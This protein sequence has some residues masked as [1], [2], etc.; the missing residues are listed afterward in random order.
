MLRPAEPEFSSEPV[1][2]W[3]AWRL[4]RT[5][6]GALRIA[7]ATPRADWEPGVA[8]KATCTGAHTRMYLV[9]NPELVS[10]HRSPEVGCTCG[11]HAVADPRRLRRAGGPVTV[12]GL[13][14]MWGR[15]IEHS[16]G[17]RAEFI[18]PARLRLVCST[19][20][21][22]GLLPAVP[23][24]VL[25]RDGILR[26]VCA[27]HATRASAVGHR[28]AVEPIQSE[29]LNT[30]GV[31]LL[32]VELLDVADDPPLGPLARLIRGLDRRR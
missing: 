10:E 3:R 21:R 15:V 26:P 8:Q 1:M 32:P 13:A 17:W 9:F 22:A 14:A 30:Y 2:G 18:Y 5:E 23:D 16:R 27:E 24:R 19:C 6:E 20:L 31:E 29:L 4:R 25:E 12:V 28:L 7:P 11:F